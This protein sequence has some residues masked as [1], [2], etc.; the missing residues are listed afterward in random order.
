MDLSGANLDGV[1][2][3][4]AEFLGADL[5]RSS[6]R[7]ADLAVCGLRGALFDEA[8]LQRACLERADL[9]WASLVGANAGG[10]DLKRAKL[11]KANL[12]RADL[13]G[14][15]LSGADLTGANLVGT[16]LHRA[17]LTGANLTGANLLGANLKDADLKGTVLREASLI[18]AVVTKGGLE[19]ADLGGN[20]MS[21]VIVE[22]P[23][24][25]RP[26]ERE[27]AAQAAAPTPMPILETRRGRLRVE[28]K[29]RVSPK[30]MVELLRA[31]GQLSVL[32]DPAGIVIEK[33]A[34][35]LS[36]N[37]MK[38]INEAEQA[39]SG[40]APSSRN[41]MVV[42]M[43]GRAA[44]CAKECLDAVEAQIKMAAT[45]KDQDANV[46]SIRTIRL[47][48]HQ[49]ENARWRLNRYSEL[50]VTDADL[51]RKVEPLVER[52]VDPLAVL[53]ELARDCVTYGARLCYV[54]GGEA[55]MA[56]GTAEAQ[57]EVK[58]LIAALNSGDWHARWSAAVALGQMGPDAAFA[59]PDLIEC[60]KDEKRAVRYTAVC[61]LSAIGPPAAN[62]AV[63]ALVTA[64]RDG[65]LAVRSEAA[66]ALKI[67]SPE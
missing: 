40:E 64:L 28:I 37:V 34:I 14:A 57:T 12:E 32:I 25:E 35:G 38:T 15:D 30:S 65:D 36:E 46:I 67:L 16:V 66:K 6:L 44:A 9:A 4:G 53:Q 33:M 55:E 19:V 47:R 59:V 49:Y 3:R 61:A 24:P 54:G 63:P 7:E 20:P 50:G 11:E 10:A 5:R 42:E 56:A 23:T 2:L 62:A 27:P 17:N 45:S 60:M 43:A 41:W 18:G 29:D 1:D 51:V 52:S 31:L 39:R 48:K 26:P 58:R 22:E 13:T 21:G 8:T